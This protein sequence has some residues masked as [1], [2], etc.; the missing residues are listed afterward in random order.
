M[1]A[2]FYR[3]KEVAEMLALSPQVVYRLCEDKVIP[4][5]KLGG[6]VR[7]PVKPLEEYIAKHMQG[8]PGD[9]ATPS[10]STALPDRDAGNR[11]GGYSGVTCGG[12]FV[13]LPREE[14][15]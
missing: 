7:V 5:I 13:H 8:L 14:V 15:S 11:S 2:R 12:G 9:E 6:S 10:Q 1:A 3:V 4:S